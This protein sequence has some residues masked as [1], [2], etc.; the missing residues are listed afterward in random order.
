MKDKYGND[1]NKELDRLDEI[2]NDPMSRDNNRV[3]SDG[4]LGEDRINRNHFDEPRASDDQRDTYSGDKGNVGTM[5]RGTVDNHNENK[6]MDNRD[7][8]TGM[9]D[10]DHD[11]SDNDKALVGLFNTENEAIN[12]VK[13]LKEIGYQEDEITVVA[14]DDDKMDRLDDATDINTKT[15]GDAGSSI[16][17]GAAIGGALGGIAAALPALGLLAIP[18]IG[19]LLAAGPIAAIVGGVVAGGVAG[20]LVGGLVELGVREEDAKKYEHQIEQGKIL[21]LVENKENYRDD[22]NNTYRQNNNIING[23]NWDR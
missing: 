9:T 8:L 15:E 16:G 23:Q 6:N 1:R 17:T 14:K 19:P 5:E 13:R 11:R 18:G 2:N 20:G 7:S 4:D 21:I 3:N 10:R 12:V 22:V